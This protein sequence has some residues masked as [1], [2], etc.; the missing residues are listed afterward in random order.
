MEI[1]KAYILKRIFPVLI[2]TCCFFSFCSNE[3][4]SCKI[5][6]RWVKAY[7]TETWENVKT[8]LLWSLSYM[9]ATLDSAYG[10]EII[11]REDSSC[12]TLD[13][14]K[15]GFDKQALNAFEVIID[16]LKETDEFKKFNAIDLSRF[17]V[18][19]EHSSW[20]Y[21]EITGVAKTIDEF[22]KRHGNGSGKEFHVYNSGVAKHQRN[23]RFVIGASALDMA[24][25]AEEGVGSLDS[26]TFTRKAYEVFD[27]MK[28]G[29][30][31]F[32]VY[33]ES[34]KLIAGSPADLSAAGKPSK[35]IWCHELVVQPLFFETTEPEKGISIAAFGLQVDSTQKQLENYRRHLHSVIDFSA[36]QAHTQ[37][38]LLYISFMEPSA[39]RLANEWQTDTVNV[40]SVFKTF[41]T[42][43]YSEFPFLGA[44]YYRRQADSL[45]GYS[46]ARVPLSVR[47]AIG[48]EPDFFRKLN[49]KK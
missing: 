24:W 47:E 40:K 15:A 1:R 5:R 9:G 10:N 28:N 12:F 32:A 25:I 43:V 19:T 30:L 41:P 29:Q 33:D 45:S 23:L 3:K 27:V 31:R 21:Y 20:H 35:C 6:L 8:G 49:K 17:L 26:G 16:S 18:L 34:G 48:N 37:G 14:I 13:L 11:E 4:E 46:A 36:K 42:H 22:Y 2:L 44:S 39:Y 38:E 7:P